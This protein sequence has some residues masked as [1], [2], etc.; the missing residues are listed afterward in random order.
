MSYHDDRARELRDQI[1][2]LEWKDQAENAVTVEQVRD[3]IAHHLRQLERLGATL[4]DDVCGILRKLESSLL[5]R[6]E[7]AR[8]NNELKYL[9][10]GE[11]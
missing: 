1:N 2:E 8:I 11:E 5:I 3:A 7:I 6:E 4:E 10:T 9:T